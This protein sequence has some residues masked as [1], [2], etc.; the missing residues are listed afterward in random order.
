MSEGDFVTI[1]A[2]SP[3]TGTWIQTSS[4]R[5]RRSSAASIL[6][7]DQWWITGGFD[8]DVLASTEITNSDNISFVPYIDLPEAR[9]T[10]NLVSLDNDRVMLLGAQESIVE[11]YIFNVSFILK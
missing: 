5:D 10:H 6:I 3:T 8:P 2:P 11:T 7:K 9:Y 4:M 1:S